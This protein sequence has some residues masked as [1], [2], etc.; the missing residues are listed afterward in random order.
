MPSSFL[1]HMWCSWGFETS[2]KVFYNLFGVISQVL[3]TFLPVTCK[4][5][6][7]VAP[8]IAV[9]Q[10]GFLVRETLKRAKLDGQGWLGV[11]GSSH[12]YPNCLST[13]YPNY[14]VLLFFTLMG[15]VL[16]VLPFPNS[17]T[18]FFIISHC[19]HHSFFSPRISFPLTLQTPVGYK[20]RWACVRAKDCRKWGSE[21][22][23]GK[24]TSERRISGY[25]L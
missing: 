3:L 4:A 1:W 20:K 16:H 21:F 7:L 24:I 17:L 10:V 6:K 11:N 22:K 13:W 8:I 12:L 2:V 14:L 23:K 15:V 19:V 25:L 9:P 18:D 5:L